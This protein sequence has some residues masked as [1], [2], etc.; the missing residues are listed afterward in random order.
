MSPAPMSALLD[1]D[2]DLKFSSDEEDQRDKNKNF[3]SISV[4]N[5]LFSP[6]S[7]R[8]Y[9]SGDNLDVSSIKKNLNF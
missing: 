7:P 3:D 2:A 6:I 9:F 8:E 5:N 4:Q 1:I